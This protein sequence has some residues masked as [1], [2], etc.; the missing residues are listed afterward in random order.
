MGQPVWPVG[1]RSIR[2]RTSRP[3]RTGSLA[4]R[5]GGRSQAV[6][7]PPARTRLHRPS[8]CSAGARK[9]FVVSPSDPAYLGTS[10]DN[11][12]S[13]TP[14]SGGQPVRSCGTLRRRG[15]VA[16]WQSKRLIIARS[17]VQIQ[18][19]LPTLATPTDA[20]GRLPGCFRVRAA[21]RD[22]IRVVQKGPNVTVATAVPPV[23]PS[24]RPRPGDPR[25]GPHNCLAQGEPNSGVYC[26]GRSV[27][28]P[29]ATPGGSDI[30]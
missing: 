13:P 6:R 5:R 24:R 18:P 20:V 25:T 16:Q 7:R 29:T 22:A 11:P 3:V 15:W 1:R 10:A 26:G 8:E 27:L 4:G 23:K 9:R 19:Q 28:A 2:P 30:H 12:G 21:P 14:R 17:L